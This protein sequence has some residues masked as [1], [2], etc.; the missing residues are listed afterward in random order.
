MKNFLVFIFLFFTPLNSTT[1]NNT[2]FSNTYSD[3]IVYQIN[4]NW[5]EGN[6]IKNLEKLRGCT[7][8]YGYL[9]EQ[10]LEFKEKI[11]S[12]P[13]VFITNKGKVVYRYQAGLSLKAD[14]TYSDIQKIVNQYR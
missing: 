5:N 11:N 4:S 10:P 7:Y 1:K 14:I 9:E 13:A 3:I 8:V 2:S 12:V 6:A